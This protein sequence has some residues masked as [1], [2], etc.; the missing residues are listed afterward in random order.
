VEKTADTPSGRVYEQLFALAR[1]ERSAVREHLLTYCFE[2]FLDRVSQSPFRDQ[3]VLKGGVLLSWFSS[4]R[5]T[6]DID[7]QT[8]DVECN[9]ETVQEMIDSIIG[10]DVEDGLNFVVTGTN[11]E[12]LGPGGHRIR[13]QI[14]ADL[15]TVEVPFHVDL[16][17]GDPIWPGPIEITL[18]RLLEGQ[19]EMLGYPVHMILAEKIITSIDPS[20]TTTRLR[21]FL[22][23]ASIAD[24]HEAD[25]S[26]LRTALEKVA[27]FREVE[28][29]PLGEALDELAP[30]VQSQ[31]VI[32]RR[33]HKLD[34]LITSRF[35][36]VLDLCIRFADPVIEESVGEGTWDP[37]GYGWTTSLIATPNT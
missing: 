9:V 33:R 2:G 8:V 6:R 17:F 19:I 3:L 5:M 12:P 37:E 22:D 25:A 34:E 26:D 27:Q 16:F 31:W 20:V 21:D 30:R 36:V 1:N 18:D 11:L 10:V 28:L 14:T 29:Q 7:L 32:W 35:H 23:I 24:A 15:D 13:V 4:R